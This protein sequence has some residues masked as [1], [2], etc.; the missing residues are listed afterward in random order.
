MAEESKSVGNENV[1]ASAEAH[2][3]TEVTDTSVSAGVGAS[4]E[5]HAGVENTNQIGDVT[6]SQEAHAEAEVHAEATTEAGWMVE[7]HQ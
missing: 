4:V 3:G 5:V 1:G 2:A 6:I 7:T